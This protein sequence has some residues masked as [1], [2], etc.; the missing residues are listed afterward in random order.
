MMEPLDGN[1]IGGLLWEVFGAEMTA[2]RAVCG[3]CGRAAAV[4]ELTVY[5]HAPGVVTRC[6][7]CGVV[8]IVITTHGDLH[9]VDLSGLSDLSQSPAVS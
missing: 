2:A 9:C 1:A 3:N 7:T 6:R 8:L 4:A 5:L